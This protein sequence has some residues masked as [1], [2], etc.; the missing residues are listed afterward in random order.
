MSVSLDSRRR[1][2]ARY[3][4][5]WTLRRQTGVNPSTFSDLA[6]AGYL[7]TYRPEQLTG[8][9]QMGDASVAILNDE[10]LAAAW[11]GPPRSKDAMIIDGRTWQVIGARAI[12]ER[13]AVIGFAIWVRGGA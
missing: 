5:P 9:V 8:G 10:I 13:T 12:F 4:R 1:M 2:I 3:G 11:P 6:V 7:S